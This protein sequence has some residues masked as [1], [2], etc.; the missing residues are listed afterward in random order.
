ML[1]LLNKY[2]KEYHNVYWPRAYAELRAHPDGWDID[3]I[4]ELQTASERY[5]YAF[6]YAE[7]IKKS[8]DEVVERI[9]EELAE[10]ARLKNKQIADLTEAEVNSI[11]LD[12]PDIDDIAP[13]EIAAQLAQDPADPRWRDYD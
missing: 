1:L 5:N 2:H 11:S 6:R 12:I 10:F 9:E 7:A 4:R 3:A 8:R 13:P